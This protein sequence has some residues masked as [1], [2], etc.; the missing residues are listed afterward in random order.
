MTPSPDLGWREG[1]LRSV[2]GWS[3][4][5]GSVLAVYVVLSSF[6]WDDRLLASPFFWPMIAAFALLPVLRHRGLPYPA[7]A[8]GFSGLL[9]VMATLALL[10]IGF[11]PGPVLVYALAV[12]ASGLFLGRAALLSTVAVTTAGIAL[13]G[14]AMAAGGGGLWS[15]DIDTPWV[16]RSALAYAMTAGCLGALALH[17]LAQVERS[18]SDRRRAER[19][20]RER[21]QLSAMGELLSGVAHEVRNPLFAITSTVDVLEARHAG[22]E[23]MR[24]CIEPVRRQTQRLQQLMDDLLEFGRPVVR[25][26]EPCRLQDVATAAQESCASLAKEHGV[27]VGVHVE[28]HLPL[29]PGSRRRLTQVFHNLIDNAIRHSDEGGSVDVLAG[30]AERDGR[31]GI[32]CVVLDGGPGFREEDRSRL[33]QPF[34]SRRKGGVGIGLALVQRIVAEHHGVI[35]ADN[36]PEGGAAMRIWLPARGDGAPLPFH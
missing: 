4:A 36:R 35:S 5:L 32:E 20:L 24:R 7:R 14:A 21:E 6:L 27:R 26:P 12:V 18:D 9:V 11:G 25:E 22:S 2:A 17:V 3:A 10:V 13:S 23:D 33:F 8:W 19:A 28:A 29:I 1:A 16:V 30:T 34:F 31:P 15:I